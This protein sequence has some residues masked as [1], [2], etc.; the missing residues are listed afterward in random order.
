MTCSCRSQDF[1][2]LVSSIY[3]YETALPDSTTQPTKKISAP[4][5]EVEKHQKITITHAQEKTS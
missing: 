3:Y 5:Q 2:L 1:T 4:T